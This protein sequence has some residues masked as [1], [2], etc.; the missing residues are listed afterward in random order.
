MQDHQQEKSKE[1]D[2]IMKIVHIT[3]T[4]L[5]QYGGIPNVLINLS[6]AQNSI[7][8]V[9]SK[10][11]SVK[12]EV[13][14]LNS[15]LFVQKTNL[16]DIKSYLFEY[17]P[18]CIIFH[19]LFFKEYIW[20]A[21]YLRNIGKKYYI[22]PHGSF[23]YKVKEKN[24]IKKE[25][26]Y[27]LVFSGF[28][29]DAYGFVFLSENEQ[30]NSMFSSKHDVIIP[31]G[32]S[33]E[34]IFNGNKKIGKKVKIFYL[35]NIDFYYKGLDILLESLHKIDVK[36]Q[37]FELN[38]YGPGTDQDIARLVME[39]SQF[40]YISVKFLGPQYNED[41]EEILRNSNIMILTSRS[42]GF[43][44]SVLEALAF[45][46]P[47]IVTRGTNVMDLI[48]NNQLGW[49]TEPENIGETIENAVSDYNNNFENYTK[50]TRTFIQDTF[51]WEKI[52]VDSIKV[53]SENVES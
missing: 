31:N 51:L 43:P 32:I 19:G 26:A 22:E 46:N 52:A 47:C 50:I 49:G 37:N 48:E 44:M 23:N 25:I 21:K 36:E 53:L 10:V 7:C 42:E 30:K 5:K 27:N 24:R 15:E 39:I 29:R 20:I 13:T 41:K 45:G 1:L 4:H 35:G 6:N 38:I 9:E 3:A 12:H 28:I 17:S 34:K 33:K 2:D 8:G 16:K 18:D 40:K 14:Q 11:L